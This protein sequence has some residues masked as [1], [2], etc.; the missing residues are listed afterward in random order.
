MFEGKKLWPLLHAAEEKSHFRTMI[1]RQKVY[2]I[3]DPVGILRYRWNKLYGA[4]DGVNIFNLNLNE[5]DR[6]QGILIRYY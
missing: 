6:L 3:P 4:T 1:F 2:P 5:G